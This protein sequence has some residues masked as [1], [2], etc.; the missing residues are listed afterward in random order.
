[1]NRNLKKKQQ[2]N[3]R[4]VTEVDRGVGLQLALARKLRGLT[5]SELGD[6]VGVKFQ[7]IQKYESGVNRISASRLYAIATELRLPLTYFFQIEGENLEHGQLFRPLKRLKP[8]DARNVL[9]ALDQ[10][11]AATRRHFVGLIEVMAKKR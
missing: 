7:Q 6:M 9:E 5:Q 8:K 11:D 10:S 4:S 3:T 1:M 2:T